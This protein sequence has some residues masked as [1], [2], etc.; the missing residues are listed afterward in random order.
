[1]ENH[2]KFN[3]KTH[4]INGHFQLPVFLT[5]GYCNYPLFIPRSPERFREFLTPL[6]SG[7]QGDMRQ[8]NLKK[9]PPVEAGEAN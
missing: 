6:L 2:H 8:M 9:N 1:M 7:G 5:F 4:E 3:G